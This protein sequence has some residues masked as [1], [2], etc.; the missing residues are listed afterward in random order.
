MVDSVFEKNLKRLNGMGNVT[1]YCSSMMENDK[2]TANFVL[3]PSQEQNFS[4]RIL[5]LAQ[6]TE[7]KK[8]RP[9]RAENDRPAQPVKR[10]PN[11]LDRYRLSR[12]KAIHIV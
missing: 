8:K 5:L 1:I 9:K 12:S 4:N 10:R 7:F 11:G 2:V 3:E 6:K